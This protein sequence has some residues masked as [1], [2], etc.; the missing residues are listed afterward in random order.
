MVNPES[1]KTFRADEL[2]K[3]LLDPFG[4]K[5]GGKPSLAKGGIKDKT[6]IE[7]I[8]KSVPKIFV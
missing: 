5:G 1:Q 3:S 2:I 7:D 8:L 4:G 6:K